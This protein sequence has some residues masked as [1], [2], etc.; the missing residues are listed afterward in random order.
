MTDVV[1]SETGDLETASVVTLCLSSLTV[2]IESLVEVVSCFVKL[3][4]LLEVSNTFETLN[5]FSE[6]VLKEEENFKVTGSSFDGVETVNGAAVGEVLNL[7]DGL[8]GG[9]TSSYLGAGGFGE[10][11]VITVSLL[12][13]VEVLDEAGMFEV[14]FLSKVKFEDTE[15]AASSFFGVIENE[16][17]VGLDA[18]KLKAIVASFVG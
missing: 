13:G 10:V 16:A 4:E 1:I 3:L 18:S 7:N 2:T 9:V 5:A 15:V 17:A 11:F 8:D 14:T 6:P 12:T